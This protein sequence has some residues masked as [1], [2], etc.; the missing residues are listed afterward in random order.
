M[1]IWGNHIFF[2]RLAL[3]S[4]L[5]QSQAV[6]WCSQ[7]GRQN[8]CAIVTSLLCTEKGLGHVPKYPSALWRVVGL[9]TGKHGESLPLWGLPSISAC[10]RN[11]ML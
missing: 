7:L 8:P 5:W 11:R 6:A 1:L 10:S 9:E 4:L 3:L 2:L